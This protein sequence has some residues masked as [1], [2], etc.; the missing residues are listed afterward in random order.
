[1]I[2]IQDRLEI[3]NS[4]IAI[5][6]L[7]VMFLSNILPNIIVDIFPRFEDEETVFSWY[8][9]WNAKHNHIL[10]RELPFL[11]FSF[12]WRMTCKLTKTGGVLYALVVLQGVYVMPYFLS[13]VHQ[14]YLFNLWGTWLSYTY[15]TYCRYYWIMKSKKCHLYALDATRDINIFDVE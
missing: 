12:E 14:S 9:L 8:L 11:F 13:N 5:N 1:M 7:F 3:I 15:F 10:Q 6:V 4:T 2:K